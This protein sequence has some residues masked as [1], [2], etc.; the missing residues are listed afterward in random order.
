M[1]PAVRLNGPPMVADVGELDDADVVERPLDLPPAPG[2]LERLE[3]EGP[4]LVDGDPVLLEG[5]LRRS[6]RSSC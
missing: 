6:R 3:D 5:V 4:G 1:E 2:R